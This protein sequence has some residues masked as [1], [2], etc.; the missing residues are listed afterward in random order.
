[1]GVS[2]HDFSLSS[3]DFTNCIMERKTYNR[4]QTAGLEILAGEETMLW[5]KIW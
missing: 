5:V 3:A 1:M 4:R 2:S